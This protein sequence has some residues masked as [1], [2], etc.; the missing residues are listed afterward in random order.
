MQRLLPNKLHQ[1]AR[2]PNVGHHLHQVDC[3]ARG[4]S[5]AYEKHMIAKCSGIA[6]GAFTASVCERSIDDDCIDPPRAQSL[7]EV[8]RFPEQRRWGGS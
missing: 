2:R 4:G 5:V 3:A 8:A 1:L 6:R 7:I